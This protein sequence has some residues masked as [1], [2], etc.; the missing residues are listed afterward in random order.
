MAP[1]DSRERAKATLIIEDTKQSNEMLLPIL[2][3]LKMYQLKKKP[4]FN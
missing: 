2:F 1:E 3:A 4:S